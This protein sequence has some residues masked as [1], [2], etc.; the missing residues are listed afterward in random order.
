MP[1]RP[2]CVRCGPAQWPPRGAQP[3]AHRQAARSPQKL[4]MP[5]ATCQQPARQP[6]ERPSRR[7]AWHRPARA[8]QPDHPSAPTP[9]RHCGEPQ[10]C[11][12][13]ARPPMLRRPRPPDV[14]VCRLP[15]DERPSVHRRAA[16]PMHRPWRD[17]RPVV[18]RGHRGAWCRPP[19]A[20]DKWLPEFP[21]SQ[22]ARSDTRCGTSRPCRSPTN[23]RRHL[24]ARRWGGSQGCWKRE[25]VRPGCGM[26]HRPE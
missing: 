11:R 26:W 9:K 4:P 2:I 10:G 13:Q 6:G 18:A 12:R 15:D 3:V 7:R 22:H 1:A 17:P 19:G 14:P 16:R 23:C 21:A 24:P 25:T 5:N 8:R 20:R